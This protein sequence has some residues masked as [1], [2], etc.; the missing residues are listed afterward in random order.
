MYDRVL[1]KERARMLLRS[2]RGISIGV[3]V[4][5]TTIFCVVSAVTLGF[6]SLF[7]M[8]P[9][10]VGLSMF[11]LGVWREENPPFET[12]LG[13]FQRYTQSLIGILWMNLW[14]FLWGLLLVIP[15]IVKA[16]AYS[17]TPYL[18]ADYPDIG[19][20]TALKISMA[21]TKGRKA[22]IF[23][24]Y[25]SFLGW[26]ILSALT[27]GILELVHVGPYFQI[28]MAGLYEGLKQDAFEE[29]RLSEADLTGW[30]DR[31]VD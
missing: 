14:I 26:H 18:L 11:F 5:Y 27:L 21:M 17:M 24:L 23:V 12:M 28:S 22:E 15:G 3:I 19:P 10:A 30:A 9:L 8:P 4:V 7:I 20:R 1:V 16:L 2:Y 31:T 13:G 25:L 29:G 6:G